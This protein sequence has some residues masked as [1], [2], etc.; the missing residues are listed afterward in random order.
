[1]KILLLEDEFALR[2]SVEEFLCDLEYRVESFS[3]SED[4]YDAIFSRYYD[5]MLLDVKVPGKNGFELLQE[6]RKEGIET[7]A[8]FITSMTMTDNMVEGYKA[9]CCDYIKKP[10]DLTELQLRIQQAL[11]NRYLSGNTTDFI[12]LEGGYRYDTKNFFLLKG[13]EKVPLS[14]T[15]KEIIDCLLRHQGSVVSN[16]IFQEEVWGEYVDPTNIRVQINKLRKKIEG[17]LIKN[18]RG[19]GY[20]I[21][22]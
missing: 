15:E 19:A 20:T 18:I 9:G 21:E 1:M 16:E 11:K 7:P 8:I 22:K 12:Q 13:S 5:L 14:K 2:E 3:T 4:A 6:V 17:D 10:F